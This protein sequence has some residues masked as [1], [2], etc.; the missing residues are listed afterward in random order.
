[1]RPSHVALAVLVTALWGINFVVI[2]I[3]ID[4]FPPLLFSVFRF[5]LAAVPLVF[6]IPKP[7]VSWRLIIGLGFVLGVVKFSLLFIG[8]DLGVSAG[9]AS[10]VLQSQAFFTVILAALVLHDHPTKLQMTGIAV[11]F[12]GI[13]LIATTVDNSLTPTGLLLV[14]AAGAAWAVYNLMLKWVGQV[15]ML[16]LMVWISL[17]PPLPLLALSMIF[18]GPGAAYI[19]ISTLN[20]QG[21]GAVIFNAFV[22][23]I[24]CFA[25]WSKLIRLYGPGKVAPF[26]LLVPIFGMSS[27]AL[28]LGE[29]FGPVRL[30][31]TGLIIL[32]LILTVLKPKGKSAN[33]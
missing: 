23:S 29:T 1:M 16:H 21:V 10:V 24:L 31:A 17:V 6:F 8:M 9:M 33:P 26:S 19:A 15:N 3:G 32:G 25:I 2:R 20:W 30:A 27:A 12:T 4:N 11:A 14:L 13:I 28:I 22:T 5:S 18:E 7:N